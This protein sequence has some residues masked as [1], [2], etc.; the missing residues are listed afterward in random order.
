MAEQECTTVEPFDAEKFRLG[1]LCKRGHDWQGSGKSL[2]YRKG[3]CAECRKACLKTPEYRARDKARRGTSGRK[4]RNKTYCKA[5]PC[6]LQVW[7]YPG[8]LRRSRCPAVRHLWHDRR[9][10]SLRS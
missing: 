8:S 6:S 5:I 1:K 3:D 2:R 9:A 4:A 7:T 10:A